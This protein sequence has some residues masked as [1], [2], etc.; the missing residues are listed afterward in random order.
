MKYYTLHIDDSGAIED[1]NYK[2]LNGNSIAIC[3]MYDD[4][5]FNK[6]NN[7]LHSTNE[8]IMD[9]KALKCFEKSNIQPYELRKAIVIRKEFFLKCIK[10]KKSYN[11]YQLILSEEKTNQY[12]NWIDF[13]KSEIYAEKNSLDSIKINSHQH[14]LDLIDCNKSNK[15][16]FYDFKITKVVFG[17]N[18]NFGIDLFQIPLYSSGIYVS[19]IFR[20][21]LSKAK[22]TDLKF[23]KNN[24]ELNKIWKPYFPEIEFSK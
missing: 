11:Y 23:L 18:F 3:K 16:E 21:K 4:N 17:K 12:Y 7:I 15:D 2:Q 14:L 24:E 22:I 20:E 8:Y 10:I 13:D 5:D 6:L 1:I 9:S 19:E